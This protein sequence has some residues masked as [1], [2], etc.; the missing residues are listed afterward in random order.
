MREDYKL[1]K[2]HGRYKKGEDIALHPNTAK[3]FM[4]H[5]LIAD[6]SKKKKQKK[7]SK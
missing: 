4:K 2:D 1:L 7:T 3:V 5:G 6:P